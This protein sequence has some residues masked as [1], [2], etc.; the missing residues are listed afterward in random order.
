MTTRYLIN[1]KSNSTLRILLSGLLFLSLVEAKAQLQ[2]FD[3]AG[4]SAGN[5]GSVR[6][7][8]PAAIGQKTVDKLTYSDVRGRCF[9][10]DEWSPGL[11]FLKGGNAIKMRQVKLNLYTN[12]VHYIDNSGSELVA[13]SGLIKK[14]ILFSTE[15][16][17]K[18]T[19]AFQSLIGLTKDDKEHYFQVMNE[20]AFQLLKNVSVTIRKSDYDP[21]LGRSEFNFVSSTNYF[22]KDKVSIKPLKGL[23]K[24]SVFSILEPTPEAEEWLKSTKNKVKNEED[25]IA[26]FSFL[27]LEKK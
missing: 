5:Y 18:V 20:G 27:S 22:L 8:N 1:P 17:L 19:A 13:N 12:D 3:V 11:L 2:T 14:I 15:D 25:I 10:S 4:G 7:N 26:L 23:N 9:W 16:T 24:S 6:Y 21:L